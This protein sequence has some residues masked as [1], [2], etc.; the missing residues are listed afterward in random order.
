MGNTVLVTGVVVVTTVLGLPWSQDTTAGVGV[1][2]V[3]R[4]WPHNSAVLL[5]CSL[6][7]SAWLYYSWQALYILDAT[8]NLVTVGR[9]RGWILRCHRASSH[10]SNLAQVWSCALTPPPLLMGVMAARELCPQ[11]PS[12]DFP[13][14]ASPHATKHSPSEVLMWGFLRPVC[15]VDQETFDGL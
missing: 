15:T 7:Q 13:W 4:S 1:G 14:P 2:L 11:T 5:P 6:W 9:G 10:Y 3:V 8:T 12:V